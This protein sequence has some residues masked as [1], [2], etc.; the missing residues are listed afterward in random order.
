MDVASILKYKL[1]WV[2]AVNT[3][4][5]VK[6]NMDGFHFLLGIKIGSAKFMFP[7]IIAKY[8]N[9]EKGTDLLE[10]GQSNLEVAFVY[11]CSSS[12]LGWWN[13]RKQ[14]QQTQVWKQEVLPGLYD[15]HDEA[16]LILSNRAK[17]MQKKFKDS[18]G[19]VIL[20]AY[21]GLRTDIMKYLHL[22]FNQNSDLYWSDDEDRGSESLDN[23]HILN[24]TIPVRF[25]LDNKLGENGGLKMAAGATKSQNRGFFN[26][27]PPCMPEH[28]C[29][30]LCVIYKTAQTPSPVTMYYGDLDKVEIE[31]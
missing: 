24:V 29:P 8:D 2:K 5:G 12:L 4:A 16:V 23:L 17:V 1:P 6:V 7:F 10:Q 22:T 18:H 9:P 15:G 21:Y 25:S 31:A 13:N 27:I 19:L 26:P 11:L 14:H 20:R 30:V 28:N 3:Y